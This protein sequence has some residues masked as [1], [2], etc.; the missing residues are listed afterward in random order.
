MFLSTI[1][2]QILC[3]I[4][5]IRYGWFQKSIMQNSM[6]ATKIKIEWVDIAGGTFLMG[7][8]NNETDRWDHETQL[9]D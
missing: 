1:K 2:Q 8:P 7:S 6:T 3:F 5:I 9:R 4:Y